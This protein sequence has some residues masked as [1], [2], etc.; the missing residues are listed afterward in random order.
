VPL[1][2]SI[3]KTGFWSLD[4]AEGATR[5]SSVDWLLDRRM[6]GAPPRI[7]DCPH[8]KVR[9]TRSHS[10]PAAAAHFK[11]IAIDMLINSA[12]ITPAASSLPGSVAAHDSVQ[13]ATFD[14]QTV[15]P[16]LRTRRRTVKPFER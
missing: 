10:I 14:C 3:G 16:L 9:H 15:L 7:K 13:V 2:L 4:G 6:W 8:R 11:D 5:G 12:G 1:G